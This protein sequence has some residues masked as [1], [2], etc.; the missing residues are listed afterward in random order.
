MS[1]WQRGQVQWFDKSS[2]E[3]ALLGDDGISYYLHYSTI[4][5]PADRS[6]TMTTG[7]NT[8]RKN[9]DPGEKVQFLVYENLYSKRVEK[10]RPA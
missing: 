4:A 7:K 6:R 5:P 2:G 3:G 8:S 9:L 1:R 10:V